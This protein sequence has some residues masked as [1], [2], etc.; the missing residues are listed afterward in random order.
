MWAKLSILAVVLVLLAVAAY[1]MLQ[2]ISLD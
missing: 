1:V 2:F